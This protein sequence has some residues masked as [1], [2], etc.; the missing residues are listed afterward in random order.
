MTSNDLI[1]TAQLLRLASPALPIGAF[2]W[3]GG[4]EGAIDEGRVHDIPSAE[5]WVHDLLTHAHG[6]WDAP[7]LWTM[8][9]QPAR[10][11][12]L[13][14]LYLASRE[15]L[16]LRAETLQTG[17]SLVRLLSTLAV[18]PS[19]AVPSLAVSP[20]AAVP[21]LAQPRPDTTLPHAWALAADA[22]HIA[23]DAALLAWFMSQLD[24]AIAV[25]Q[26]ALPLG[27]VAAQRLYTSLIPLLPT[28]HASA[29]ALPEDDWSSSLP[30]LAC[31]S[32]RHE[33]QYSRLFRS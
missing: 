5:R 17:G 33:Q 2:A 18:S 11:Q 15:T 32:S 27:Q 26:K 19:A 7:I 1:A 16:E 23:P 14:A 8:L 6:R 30:G 25:L 12:A 3:S 20:L 9:T 28:I 4:L 21:S 24:N 31:I 13:D 29:K 10:R 22:W